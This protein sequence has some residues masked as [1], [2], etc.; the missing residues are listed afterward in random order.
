MDVGSLVDRQEYITAKTKIDYDDNNPLKL[1]NPQL[2][3][4]TSE[5]LLDDGRPR[6]GRDLK[7]FLEREAD[8]F[9]ASMYG[10]TTR[11]NLDINVQRAFHGVSPGTEKIMEMYYSGNNRGRRMLRAYPQNHRELRE[12]VHSAGLEGYYRFGIN[13]EQDLSLMVGYMCI[14][15][16]EEAGWMSFVARMGMSK[17]VS[18]KFHEV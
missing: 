15:I 14:A 9:F 1:S 16:R 5:L 6:L 17:D 12:L 8:I 10:V 7:I 3:G 13:L 11:N 18:R 4:K 2:R